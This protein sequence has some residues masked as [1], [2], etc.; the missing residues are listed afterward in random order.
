MSIKREADKKIIK[1]LK[2]DRITLNSTEEEILNRWRFVN[3]QMRLG[4]S[5]VEIKTQLSDQYKVSGFIADQDYYTA[6]AVFSEI[7]RMDKGYL[8]GIHLEDL[9]MDIVKYRELIYMNQRKPSEKEIAA[10]SKLAE[11]Y[12]Y[13]LNSMPQKKESKSVLPPMMIFSLP[14]GR[15]ILPPMPLN[16]A[17]QKAD[18][19]IQEA[20]I[21]KTKVNVS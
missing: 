17:L 1:F 8:L 14:N 13:A 11:S 19:I 10:L 9:R 15:E 3:D 16:I 5:A 21:I 20:E 18:E 6:Q 4:K 7:T 2:G 12:T